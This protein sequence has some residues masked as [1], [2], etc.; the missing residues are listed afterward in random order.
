MLTNEA[1][2]NR[3]IEIMNDK[4]YDP[5]EFVAVQ[6]E[7]LRRMSEGYQEAVAKDDTYSE[8]MSLASY[9]SELRKPI[10]RYGSDSWDVWT[11]NGWEPYRHGL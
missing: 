2:L 10:I 9:L 5:D 7:I 11:P 3:L 8:R 4:A 6:N 1:L